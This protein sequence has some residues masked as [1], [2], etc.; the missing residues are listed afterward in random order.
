MI[1]PDDVFDP[2]WDAPLTDEQWL[3]VRWMFEDRTDRPDEP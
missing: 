1:P 2:E 3:A